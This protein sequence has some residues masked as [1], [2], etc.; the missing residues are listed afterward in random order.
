MQEARTVYSPGDVSCKYFN[1]F[2]SGLEI[3]GI[4][5]Y[6]RLCLF[7]GFVALCRLVILA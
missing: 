7:G 2:L 4:L 5:S 3:V 1:A 6:I